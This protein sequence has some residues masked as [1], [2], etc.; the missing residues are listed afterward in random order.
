MEKLNDENFLYVYDKPLFNNDNSNKKEGIS[1]RLSSYT[2]DTTFSDMKFSEIKKGKDVK[3][4]E[5]LCLI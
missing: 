4:V 5:L 2:L 1:N 3:E